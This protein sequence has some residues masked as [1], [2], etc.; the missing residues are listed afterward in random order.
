M[1]SSQNK[2]FSSRITLISRFGLFVD[3]N[4]FF[5]QNRLQRAPELASVYYDARR[6]KKWLIF[7][8]EA[9]SQLESVEHSQHRQLPNSVKITQ[10]IDTAFSTTLTLPTIKNVDKC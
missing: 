6:I 10:Q 4:N 2:I 7:N 8:T 5:Y 3:K 1:D 9:T